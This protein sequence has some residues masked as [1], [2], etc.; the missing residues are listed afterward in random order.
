VTAS[1]EHVDSVD[2]FMR[3][4]FANIEPLS[5]FGCTRRCV[6][7]VR[8]RLLLSHA[9][10]HR[11]HIGASTPLGTVFEALET[12]RVALAIDDYCVYSC[13]L[14][15]VFLDLIALAAKEDGND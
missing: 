12:N 3:R 4:T 5:D 8:V 10:A 1:S 7:C 9:H 2:A 13:Q 11:Y 14:E 6:C 15:S